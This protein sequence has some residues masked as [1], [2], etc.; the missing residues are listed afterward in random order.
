MHTATSSV[1]NLFHVQAI[2][3]QCIFFTKASTELP[4]KLPALVLVQAYL[5][6]PLPSPSPSPSV[7]VL[8]P[9]SISVS[10]SVSVSV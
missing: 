1:N 5:P 10:G 2:Y 6:W 9:V 4:M 8:V 3:K 7:S